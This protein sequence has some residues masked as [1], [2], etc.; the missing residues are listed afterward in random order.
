MKPYFGFS[1]ISKLTCNFN[2]KVSNSKQRTP[3]GWNHQP[4]AI[5]AFEPVCLISRP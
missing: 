2:G 3:M 4:S 1:N 5:C